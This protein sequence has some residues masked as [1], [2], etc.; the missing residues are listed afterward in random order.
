[1]WSIWY[2]LILLVIPHLILAV[3]GI[4]PLLAL[5]FLLVVLSNICYHNHH[6]CVCELRQKSLKKRRVL[7]FPGSQELLTRINDCHYLTSQTPTEKQDYGPQALKLPR[8]SLVQVLWLSSSH[9]YNL[10]KQQAFWGC[11]PLVIVLLAWNSFN[12]LENEGC[13]WRDTYRVSDVPFGTKSSCFHPWFPENGETSTHCQVQHH[14][15]T[16]ARYDVYF[17]KDFHPGVKSF[18]F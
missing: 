18:I 16:P 14:S 8:S 7:V 2:H 4:F 10:V 3:H 6:Q 13:T 11:S 17:C 1:M 12:C 9:R 5:I 15:L